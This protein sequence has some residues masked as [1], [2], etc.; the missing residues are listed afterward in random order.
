MLP[1]HQSPDFVPTGPL[2]LYPALW[3]LARVRHAWKGS[4]PCGRLM[5]SLTGG[6]L[7][8]LRNGS[9]MSRWRTFR[10]SLLKG[11]AR[12][13]VI[14]FWAEWC[15]P[16]KLLAPLLEKLAEEK[17][18]GF[19]LVK[20]NVDENPDLAQAFQVEGIPAVFAVRDGQI[21]NQFS[22]MI[23]EEELR[24]FIDEL[25]TF[26]PAE[27]TALEVATELEARDPKA[28]R[29]AYRAML[30]A[31]PDDPAARV[32]LARVLLA[33][34]GN[35]LESASLLTGLDFGDFAAEAQR[36]NAIV[37]LRA[38]PHTD[39]DLATAKKATSNESKLTLAHVLAAR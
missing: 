9:S 35:E 23:P 25:G 31:A 14:D 21:A 15:R 10:T 6:A 36:L 38:V 11:R 34:P 13:V 19:L 24:A 26:T 37:Q 30:A 27:P 39:A 5:L 2:R 1:L 12:P 3:H 29:E 22:G 33:A 4:A 28:A 18:G 32:G 17:A 8:L 16:C 7:W 20:V